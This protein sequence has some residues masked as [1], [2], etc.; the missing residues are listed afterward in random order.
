MDRK[1]SGRRERARHLFYTFNM[2]GIEKRE[3]RCPGET[4]YGQVSCSSI[5]DGNRRHG[6]RSG[7]KRGRE[8]HQ[9]L[10]RTSF[11][12]SLAFKRLRRSP[13]R[14]LEKKEGK[15][16]RGRLGSCFLICTFPSSCC[17]PPAW[18]VLDFPEEGE[19]E[20]VASGSW[21]PAQLPLNS[22]L[23]FAHLEERLGGRREGKKKRGGEKGENGRVFILL[24]A[25]LQAT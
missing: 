20:K 21:Q 18:P 7:G 5:L 13:V 3:R 8:S 12:P 16:G 17:S 22:T 1:W 15:R 6:E 9:P 2:S 4:F 19:K 24:G 23:F 10:Q 25:S 11:C 14:D